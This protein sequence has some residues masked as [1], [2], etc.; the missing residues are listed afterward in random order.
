VRVTF[1][2]AIFS[3]RG[4]RHRA[5]GKLWLVHGAKDGS[6]RY[7]WTIC[8]LPLWLTKQDCVDA[9]KILP[10]NIR[11]DYPVL[12]DLEERD[13]VSCMECLMREAR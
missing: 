4:V 8:G 10:Q 9:E 13:A 2:Y 3:A 7:R 6:P 5:P 12:D 1:G 11:T